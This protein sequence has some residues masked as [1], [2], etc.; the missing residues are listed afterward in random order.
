LISLSTEMINCQVAFD[1]LTQLI[2]ASNSSI[3]KVIDFPSGSTVESYSVPGPA[4]D[5]HLVY[6]K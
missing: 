2:Y 3:L 6:N 5:L 1:P 4:V